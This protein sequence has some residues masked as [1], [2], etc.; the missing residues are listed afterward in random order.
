MLGWG[1]SPPTSTYLYLTLRVTPQSTLESHPGLWHPPLNIGHLVSNHLF[2][3]SLVPVL[4]ECMLYLIPRCSDP[5]L[6]G[7]DRFS[8]FSAFVA[9]PSPSI[10]IQGRIDLKDY[11]TIVVSAL[12]VLQLQLMH[13][14]VFR[15]WQPKLND[16]PA[17]LSTPD[18]RKKSR[19]TYLGHC[20]IWW[21]TSRVEHHSTRFIDA[22]LV[23]TW[24]EAWMAAK[25]RVGVPAPS[26]APHSDD[27]LLHGDPQR[28]AVC[29][30]VGAGG[31][32]IGGISDH[33]IIWWMSSGRHLTTSSASAILILSSSLP[34][35]TIIN[36]LFPHN[37]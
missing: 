1:L 28:G 17:A 34:N 37:A 13:A 2:V 31:A 18:R 10:T 5:T 24:S 32:D 23:R 12:I 19:T 27:S 16:N 22:L 33:W 11:S 4:N 35:N 26:R 20:R 8:T 14:G 25:T 36:L 15:V 30:A 6:V 29:G 3:Y 21:S 9:P 7:L